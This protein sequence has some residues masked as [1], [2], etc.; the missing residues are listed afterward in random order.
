MRVAYLSEML[1]NRKYFKKNVRN[2]KNIQKS[3]LGTFDHIS[4]EPARIPGP[5]RSRIK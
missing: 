5:S 2:H 3:D 1:G 4:L